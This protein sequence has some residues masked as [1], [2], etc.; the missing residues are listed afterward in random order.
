MRQYTESEQG[1]L[2]TMKPD[3]RKLQREERERRIHEMDGGPTE[4]LPFWK[5]SLGRWHSAI[6]EKSGVR[7]DMSVTIL[8]TDEGWVARFDRPVE[9]IEAEERAAKY[10]TPVRILVQETTPQKTRKAAMEAA[11]ELV[12]PVQ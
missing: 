2:E 4:Y 12:R 10:G 3:M 5:C 7:P 1:E 11:L 6:V 8:K 9:D